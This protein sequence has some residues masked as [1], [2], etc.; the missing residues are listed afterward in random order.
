MTFWTDLPMRCSV[1]LLIGTL[2]VIASIAQTSVTGARASLPGGQTVIG[3]STQTSLADAQKLVQRGR[4]TEALQKLNT[5]AVQ[6]PELAGVEK[7]RGMVLYQQDKLED[8]AAAFG[9]AAAQYPLD[10]EASQM[11]GMTLFRLGRPA[12]AIPLLERKREQKIS[13]ANKDG[14]YVLGLCYMDTRRYD[15]AR[16]VFALQ[17]G[18]ATDSAE[19]YLLTARLFFR[20]DYLPAAIMAAQKA[21]QLA[22]KMPLVHELLGEIALVQSRNTDAIAEFQ[23]ERTIDPLYGGLYDRLGDAYLRA[24][25][26]PKAQQAL[27]QAVLLEP[28]A[29]GP[30][31]LLGKALLKQGNAAMA[32]MYLEHARNMDPN[33]YMIRGLLAQAYRFAGR[34]EDATR[35]LNR[36]IALQAATAPKLQAP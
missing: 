32:T 33:N 28:A 27:N 30:Y 17:Y 14:N 7:L 36:A 16:R 23:Q 11:E 18:F 13:A 21:A 24:G 2:G 31:I 25:E 22:P 19:A 9:R 4:L 20:R 8:A 34:K 3:H 5:L 15:D 26:Y 6:K 1:V 29:T 35:E 10:F 12:D